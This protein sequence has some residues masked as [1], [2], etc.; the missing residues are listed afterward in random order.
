MYC[1]KCGKELEEGVRFCSAC[2]TKAGSTGTAGLSLDMSGARSALTGVLGRVKALGNAGSTYCVGLVTL[3]WSLFLLNKAMITI[4]YSI[5]G[6]NELEITMFDGVEFL[7]TCFYIAYV[8]AIAGLLLPLF[9]GKGWKSQHFWLGM[10]VPLAATLWL[11]IARVS[12]PSILEDRVGS[13]LL[14]YVDTEIGLTGVAWLF[15][16]LSVGTFFVVRGVKKAVS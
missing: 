7:R 14:S 15:L 1:Q 10:L 5:F 4:T 12:A 2:G 3:I 9:T 13:E 11:L 16:I 8:A 6:T